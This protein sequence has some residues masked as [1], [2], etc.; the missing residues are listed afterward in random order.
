MTAAPPNRPLSRQ[1]AG[2]TL[3]PGPHPLPSG[4]TTQPY[5]PTSRP[6]SGQPGACTETL[7]QPKTKNPATGYP[8]AGYKSGKTKI[9]PP[10]DQGGL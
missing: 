4:H 3:T 6:L 2:N 5:P 1:P 10:W 9:K 8:T 7:P